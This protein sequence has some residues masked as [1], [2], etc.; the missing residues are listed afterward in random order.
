MSELL[1]RRTDPALGEF[2]VRRVDLPTDLTLLHE[3]LTHPK[4]VFWMMQ[5]AELADV[6]SM[7]REIASTEGHD[8]LLGFHTGQPSFLIETY[9]PA[10]GEFAAMYESAPGDI[11]M[12]FL[13]APTERPLHGFT[14]AVLRTVAEYL[15]ADSS[16]ERIVVDPDVRNRAVHVLNEA[17]GF[18][19]LGLVAL[20]GKDAYLSTCTR[21]QYRK[22]RRRAEKPNEEEKR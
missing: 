7:F 9:D 22:A 14:L 10:A 4:S 18:E 20:R 19:V 8:A 2:T 17:V 1:F 13:A 11:G 16:N 21:E 15:F 5:G 6:E 12:H 3:W